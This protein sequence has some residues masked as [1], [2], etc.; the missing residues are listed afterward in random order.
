MRN[1]APLLCLSLIAAPGWSASSDIVPRGSVLN[2]A[3]AKMALLNALPGYSA[4][5]FSGDGVYTRQQLALIL[6]GALPDLET[7]NPSEAILVSLRAAASDLSPELDADGVDMG[8]LSSALDKS[9]ASIGGFVQP[10]YRI[11]TG[12]SSDSGIGAQGVYRVTALGTYN[13]RLQYAVSLSDW[14]KEWRRDLNND[15]GDHSFTPV[16]EAYVAWKGSHGLE[17]RAGRFYNA[18]GPGTRGATLMSDNAPPYDQI[19]LRFPFSLGSRLGRNYLYTQ[20]AGFFKEYGATK[21]L[22][23]RRIE[24]RFSRQWN[25]DVQEAFKTTSAGALW[26]TPLP[27]NSQ[28]LSLDKLIPGARLKNIDREFNYTVNLGAAY[29]PSPDDRIYGQFFIDDLRSPFG[30]TTKVVPRKISYLVGSAFKIP[31]GPS[32]TLEY[33]YADPTTYAFQSDKAIW[34]NG[35]HNWM[36]LPSGPNSSEIYLG[37][38]QKFAGRITA[39][40]EGR[41]RR[42]PHNSFPAP[43]A[44]AFGARV[45][46]DSTPSS[47]FIVGYYDYKQN[48][49]PFAP[50][51]PG[52]PP[53][54][55]LTPVGEGD[56]GTYVRRREVDLS[57]QF[58]F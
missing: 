58:A 50:G 54:T 13:P 37:V 30:S 26:A 42:R 1:A 44:S 24:Y 12:G 32:V 4:A 41:E 8:A 49:F 11:K 33:T 16:N 14:P 51:Q 46:Y 15:V 3:F 23:T 17:L 5:D 20:T 48:P 56:Q 9:G 34:Q 19:R 28:A 52:Y 40:V 38:T 39:T 18:W 22:E 6:E 47:A 25:A 27:L 35:T 2:D 31:Q 36:G 10:E 21:Y 55:G 53:D 45:R 29:T 43:Q 57:Y 7:A